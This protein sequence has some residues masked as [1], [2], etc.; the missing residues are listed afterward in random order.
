[1]ISSES[2]YNFYKE[3][4]AWLRGDSE[5]PFSNRDGLCV[6]L[7]DYA[8]AMGYPS[9]ALCVEMHKQFEEAGLNELLPFNKDIPY[10]WEVEN[11]RTDKNPYRIEWVHSRLKESHLHYELKSP[12]NKVI[13]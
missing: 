2:L 4:A 5:F 10:R 11:Y 8:A 3:Y 6:N 7:Y 1:M 13:R 9:G 12:Q